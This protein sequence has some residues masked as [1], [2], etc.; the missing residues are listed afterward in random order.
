MSARN[1]HWLNQIFLV[2][3]NL[4]KKKQEQIENMCMSYINI[5]M[6]QSVVFVCVCVCLSID[7]KNNIHP[8]EYA[9]WKMETECEMMEC[10]EMI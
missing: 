6:N 4:Q 1:I 9:S 5:R 2:S 3:E 7:I 10:F 8:N